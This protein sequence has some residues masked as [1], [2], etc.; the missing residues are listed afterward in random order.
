METSVATSVW[1]SLA[2]ALALAALHLAA[3][4]LRRRGGGAERAISSFGG[5]AA[6]AYVFLHL[7]PE[8]A[9]GN[10]AIAK[11]LEDEVPATPLLDLGVFAVA[12]AGF[13]LFFGLERLARGGG[14]ERRE[15]EGRLFAVH[16]A[17]YCVYNALIVYTMPLRLRTGVDF[18]LLFT[19]AMA[20]HLGLT[21]RGLEG[22][23][24]RRFAG[25]GRLV[26]AGALL[27]GWL[28]AAV[29]APASTILVSVLTAF[30]G[31][32]V[33]LNVFKEELPA[34]RRLSF[35]WLLAGALLYAVLLALVTAA[36]G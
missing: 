3:P 8:I 2:I 36:S 18:A 34:G 10:E 15:P 11:A 1:L 14:D 20:L 33:L 22:T 13:L 24:P 31:G 32:S 9:E 21:D 7:L 27:A 4:A 12:L 29:A 6:V 23:Y 16:L 28:A 5:G 17:G 30:L 35:P 26:L 25:W 19:V